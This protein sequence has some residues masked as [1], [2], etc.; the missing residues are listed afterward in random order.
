MKYKRIVLLILVVMIFAV[1]LGKS[2]NIECSEKIR[3]ITENVKEMSE[4]VVRN[5][6]RA[7]GGKERDKI[8][9]IIA[10]VRG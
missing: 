2:F 5:S 1:L 8:E 10:G 9:F 6:T 4:T 7:I 3:I